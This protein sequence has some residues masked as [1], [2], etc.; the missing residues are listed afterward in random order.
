MITKTGTIMSHK[1][2]EV[3]SGKTKIVIPGFM[4]TY[5]ELFVQSKM[6]ENLMPR[7]ITSAD[8]L[9]E[10]NPYLLDEENGQNYDDA[11]LEGV[12]SGILDLAYDVLD[13]GG[14]RWRPVLGLMFAEA[15][16]R[17]IKDSI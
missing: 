14:K 4:K 9:R 6:M 15:Y 8:Q 10:F 16:G 1:S 3:G 17:D 7:N 13:S 2:D 12:N 5:S 11:D